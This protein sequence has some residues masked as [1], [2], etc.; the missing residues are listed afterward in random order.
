MSG[1]NTNKTKHVIGTGSPIKKPE[2]VNMTKVVKKMSPGKSQLANL[3]FVAG[4]TAGVMFFRAEKPNKNGADAYVNDL[5]EAL[6][7]KEGLCEELNIVKVSK[8]IC[9]LEQL[10][11]I[12]TYLLNLFCRFFSTFVAA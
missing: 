9:F 6:F 8:C 5:T 12:I 3:V 7:E 2:R 10:L 11:S 4:T 1:T